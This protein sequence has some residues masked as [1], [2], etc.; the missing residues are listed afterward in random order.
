MEKDG[1]IAASLNKMSL[2]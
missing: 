1:D 2:A